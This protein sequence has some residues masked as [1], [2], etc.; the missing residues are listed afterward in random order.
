MS[1]SITFCQTNHHHKTW[2]K[3]EIIATNFERDMDTAVTYYVPP[4]SGFFFFSIAFYS[5]L[6]FKDSMQTIAM[7]NRW[8]YKNQEDD[9]EKNC[10]QKD[11]IFTSCSFCNHNNPRSLMGHFWRNEVCNRAWTRDQTNLQGI[12]Y[13]SCN[14]ALRFIAFNHWTHHSGRFGARFVR[15]VAAEGRNW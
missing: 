14:H 11:D 12:P 5:R 15:P 6:G 2:T 13:W 1:A 8:R 7:G 4:Q 3:W 10:H 9:Q